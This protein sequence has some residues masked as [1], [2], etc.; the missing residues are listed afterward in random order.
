M[1]DNNTDRANRLSKEGL[2]VD[3]HDLLVKRPPKGPSAEGLVSLQWMGPVTH[4]E[5]LGR[6]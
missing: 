1:A 5:L 2:Q 6:V 3:F 4:G